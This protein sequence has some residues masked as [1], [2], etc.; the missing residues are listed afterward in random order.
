MKRQWMLVLLVLLVLA[1]CIPLTLS[2]QESY[3]PAVDAALADVNAR[4]GT[5]YR[6]SHLVNWYWEERTFPD[7]SMGC[8]ARGAEY[9]QVET[10][11]FVIIL[12][13][14]NQMF[15][16]RATVGS[17]TAIFCTVRPAVITVPAVPTVRPSDWQYTSTAGNFNPSLAWSPSGAFIAVLQGDGSFAE[18]AVILLYNPDDLRATPTQITLDQPVTAL[19]CAAALPIAT[20]TA[21][22]DTNSAVYLL[23]GGSSGT[24][25]LLRVD[26]PGAAP[27]EMQSQEIARRVTAVAISADLRVVAS[28]NVPESDP[29]ASPM[30]AF[31]LWDAATGD[32]LRS[33]DTSAPVVSLDF[34]PMGTWLAAG[35]TSGSFL[36]LNYVTGAVAA[37][38]TQGDAPNPEG[39]VPVRFSPDGLLLAT[40]S[41]TQI[42]VWSLSDPENLTPTRT[43]TTDVPVRALDFSPDSTRLAAAGGSPTTR[44]VNEGVIRTWTVT[45]GELEYNLRAHIGAVNSIAFSPDGTRLTSVSYDGT[46]RVWRFRPTG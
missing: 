28:A 16:Y 18:T 14:H 45:T 46:L 41:G 44:S 13:V 40:A 1:L 11:G 19:D 42:T 15:E 35:T 26:A 8:P 33:I 43:F 39:L 4:L 6:L 9:A 36:L 27:I 17:R 34:N 37:D 30:A 7:A 5:S 29:A 10:P 2:A 31:Y 38:M 21:S 32:Y 24:I 20:P 12:T 22:D 3:P 25:S 23:T